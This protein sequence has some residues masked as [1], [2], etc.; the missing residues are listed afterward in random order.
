[1]EGGRQRRGGGA[2]A[3]GRVD[4]GQHDQRR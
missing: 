1:L 2:R 3:A 4:P